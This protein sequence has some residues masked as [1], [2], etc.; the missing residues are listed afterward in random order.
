M[1]HPQMLHDEKFDHFQTW[2][3]NTQHVT[4]RRNRM[5]K[6]TQHVSPNNVA[7]VWLKQL[8]PE[9]KQRERTVIDVQLT[10]T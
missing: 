6:R 8:K 1:P 2:A 10:L 7:I 4:T 9:L 3:N 5:A